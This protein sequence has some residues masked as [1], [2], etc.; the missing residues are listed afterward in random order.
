MVA[1]VENGQSY[2]VIK[3]SGRLDIDKTPLF[4]NACLR[5]F[6]GQK[7]V[8]SLSNL[9][10]VGSTGIQAFFQAIKEIQAQ[11][12]CRIIGLSS[13]FKRMLLLDDMQG[14]ELHD[15]LE[16]AELTWID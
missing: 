7:I 5:Q 6:Q 4:K 12:Q 11:N 3:I 16:K 8:F 10:F 14:L 1:Q 2:T 9:N 15:S 13:D